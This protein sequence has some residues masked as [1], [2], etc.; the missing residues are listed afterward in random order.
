MQLAGRR[1]VVWPMWVTVD[2]YAARAADTFTAIMIE[3]NHA[4]SGTD[5]QFIH[6]VKRFQK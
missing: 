6:I 5:T 1:R 2:D 3:F 4:L